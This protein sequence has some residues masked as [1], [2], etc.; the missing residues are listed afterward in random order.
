MVSNFL[1]ESDF[2]KLNFR[3]VRNFLTLKSQSFI[4]DRNV[5]AILAFCEKCASVDKSLRSS[6]RLLRDTE[7][8]SRGYVLHTSPH[9]DSLV[10]FFIASGQTKFFDHHFQFSD[11]ADSTEK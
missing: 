2:S 6:L 7:V 5:K 10:S 11:G 3:S 9:S 1:I 4:Y 8:I